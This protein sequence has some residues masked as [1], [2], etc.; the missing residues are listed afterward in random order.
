MKT[1]EDILNW[2][3]RNRSGFFTLSDAIWVNP[4]LALKEFQASRLQA[5][6]LA[7]RGF[8]ITWDIGGLNTAFIAEW[9]AGKPVIG[10]LGEYDALL[11]LSQTSSP[12]PEPQ[13]DGGPGH[14]CGH[15][16]LGVAGLAAAEAVKEWLQATGTSGIV[17]YYGCPAEESGD[18]KVYMAR[19]GAFDDLDVAFNFHPNSF[20]TASK[21]STVGVKDIRYR[22]HGVSSHAGAEP[23]LGR[24][25]LDAVELMNVGVNYLREHVTEKVRIHYTITHG[26]DLPNV[27]P[28]QAEVWYFIRA[29]KNEELEEV[30]GRVRKI[31]QGAAMMTGTRL[32]EIFQGACS[33]LLS[34]HY[35][36]DLQYEAMQFIGP[37]QFTSEEIEYARTMLS[38]YPNASPQETLKAHLLPKHPEIFEQ[39]K[40][41]VLVSENYPALDVGEIG[42]GSTDVGDV[43]QITPLSELAT[44]CTPLGVPG[45][46]WGITAASG[47]SIG[48]KG[49][50]HAAKIMALAAV[51]CYSDPQHVQKA[52]QEFEK[53]TK[54]NPYRCPIPAD[55]A[56][57]T[58]PN[59]T[60]GQA[61]QIP[62]WR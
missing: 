33:S 29:H 54:N 40:D 15:N 58:Y 60:R 57:R 55:M 5:D 1:K 12:Y 34:N 8:T 39:L 31:A 42:T 61:D 14:G 23:H 53:A 62:S 37:L 38:H 22:F 28:P 49:M 20:N 6:Y 21:G 41:K 10:F 24:S 30:T 50:L 3:E 32:E 56:P 36:A 16:L 18:G 46:T 7:E 51:D 17:R 26:G 9:G 47:S 19:A 13:V 35:L 59:P 44:T 11:N 52:R 43:S 27:V 2:L 25:A 45:H 4:E 48:H